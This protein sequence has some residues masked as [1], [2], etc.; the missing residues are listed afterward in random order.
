[1]AIPCTNQNLSFN[2][3]NQSTALVPK[4]IHT[5]VL[6]FSL[7][8]LVQL[9]LS[10]NTLHTHT[11]ACPKDS[12]IYISRWMELPTHSNDPFHPISRH[13]SNLSLKW[14]AT[15]H[16]LSYVACPSLSWYHAELSDCNSTDRAEHTEPTYTMLALVTPF[17]RRRRAV[18]PTTLIKGP[19]A[20]SCGAALPP[21]VSATGSVEWRLAG[22]IS[23]G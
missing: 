6:I 22:Y 3:P 15:S 16:I 21:P 9:S 1:M 10:Q 7:M 4:N 23:S 18:M 2:A 19:M 8:L 20:G 12:C 13:T 17:T 14:L 11:S 5:D